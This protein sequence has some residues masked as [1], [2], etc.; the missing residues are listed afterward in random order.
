MYMIRAASDHVCYSG[1]SANNSPYIVKYSGQ[2]FFFQ[3]T[4]GVFDMKNKMNVNVGIC[5][6]HSIHNLTYNY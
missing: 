2:I 3:Y 6:A 1:F 5:F 4:M